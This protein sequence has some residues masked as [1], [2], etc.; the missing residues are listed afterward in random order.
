MAFK[1]G[2][3]PWHKSKIEFCCVEN[4]TSR[5]YAKEMCI[6]HYYRFRKYGDPTMGGPM[7]EVHR[8]RFTTEY[9]IWAGMKERCLNPT[10]HAYHYYG[11]R[12]ITIC[13][14]WRDSFMAFYQYVGKRPGSEYSIDRINN[15]GNYEPGNVRWATRSEQASNRRKPLK[16]N[17]AS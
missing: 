3:V 15:D 17:K 5:F 4:C 1:K 13:D 12:G 6:A 16:Y 10:N 7:Q 2:H 8:M 14:E 9:R 11:G